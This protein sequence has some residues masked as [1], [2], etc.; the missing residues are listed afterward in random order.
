MAAGGP[1]PLRDPAAIDFPIGI[2][3]YTGPTGMP[4]LAQF[5]NRARPPYFLGV[6][7]MDRIELERRIRTRL[8]GLDNLCNE[9][10]IDHIS[11]ENGPN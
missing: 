10:N 1:I 9:L 6:I 2:S 7:C 4:P 3:A 8:M 11:L 5:L